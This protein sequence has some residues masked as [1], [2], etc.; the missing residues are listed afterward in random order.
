IG[1]DSRGYVAND[2]SL[3]TAPSAMVSLQLDFSG[4]DGDS[5]FRRRVL[6]PLGLNLERHHQDGG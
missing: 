4:G 3:A 2:D 1:T 6:P 5:A